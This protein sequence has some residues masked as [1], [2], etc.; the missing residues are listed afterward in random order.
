MTQTTARVFGVVFLLIGVLGLVTT[1]FSMAP[2][3]LLD[4]FPVNVLH[5]L[6]H[7]AFGAWGLVAGGSLGRASA[8]CR[9]GGVAYLT[10]AV[11]GL[12]TPTG[13]GLVPLGGHDI[14][15]HAVLGGILV[16]VGFLARPHPAMSGR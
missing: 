10:L 9:I 2:D 15:L 16:A 14:W 13:F 7:L 4:L 12:L 11:V 8:Y 6:V 3:L 1:P 5:N